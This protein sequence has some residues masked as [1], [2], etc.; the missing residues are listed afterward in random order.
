MIYRLRVRHSLLKRSSPFYENQIT[1]LPQTIPKPGDQPVYLPEPNEDDTGAAGTYATLLRQ[2]ARDNFCH[3]W[4]QMAG[5]HLGMARIGE[6]GRGMEDGYSGVIW[7]IFYVIGNFKMM[8]CVLFLISLQNM[9]K[10]ISFFYLEFLHYQHLDLY[11]WN[12]VCYS[13]WRRNTGSI[14]LNGDMVV[15]S[16]TTVCP[17]H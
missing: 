4:R 6:G 1:I 8:F 2:V 17:L 14:C 13:L 16:P 12:R 15:R 11:L 10:K 9:R 3:S 7:H 5:Q